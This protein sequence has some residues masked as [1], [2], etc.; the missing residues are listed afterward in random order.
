MMTRPLPVV[1]VSGFASLALT[2]AL[3]AHAGVI[4]EQDFTSSATLG[5]YVGPSTTTQ[6]ASIVSNVPDT[7][8]TAA[9]TNDAL[10]FTNVPDGN[11]TPTG[12]LST[13]TSNTFGSPELLSAQFVV[14]ASGSPTFTNNN[15]LAEIQLG[16]VRDRINFFFQNGVVSVGLTNTA[17]GDRAVVSGGGAIAITVYQNDSASSEGY[18]GPDGLAHTLDADKSTIFVGSTLVSENI[19]PNNATRALT[20]MK[21]EFNTRFSFANLDD[22]VL[23]FDSIVVRDDLNVIPEPASLAL[24]G[25]G[26]GMMLVRRRR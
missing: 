25:A 20:G 22:G 8:G 18:I 11:P 16:A 14:T 24:L 3:P 2:F 19:N 7:T 5:D 26:V 10:T 21:F 17:A 1:L 13:F 6:F 23:A 15:P 4:F 12:V 9:I